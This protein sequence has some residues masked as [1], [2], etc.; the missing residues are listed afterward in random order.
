MELLGSYNLS[1]HG[2]SSSLGLITKGSKSLKDI[3]ICCSSTTSSNQLPNLKESFSASNCDSNTSPIKESLKAIS[4]SNHGDVL[5]VVDLLDVNLIPPW[6]ISG[7]LSGDDIGGFF[8]QTYNSETMVFFKEMVGLSNFEDNYIIGL[9]I[10]PNLKNYHIE[11]HKVSATLENE[12]MH[13]FTIC[14]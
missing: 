11:N 12:L 5:R 2:V 8:V 3:Q 4:K 14:G 1:V 6:M 10:N 9:L 7:D 13:K